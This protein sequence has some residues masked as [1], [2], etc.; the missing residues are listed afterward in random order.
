MNSPIKLGEPDRIF[1]G[2]DNFSKNV[3]SKIFFKKNGKFVWSHTLSDESAYNK[4]G[5]GDN[6][7]VYQISMNFNDKKSVDIQNEFL[8]FS[9]LKV[10]EPEPIKPVQKNSKTENTENIGFF[11]SIK[12]M[13]FN[14]QK[15]MLYIFIA[16]V[17]ITL[18]II[19][20]I[21]FMN[22][23]QQQDII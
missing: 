22:K 4:T 15:Y 5:L 1:I 8:N 21:F 17:I 23:G 12:N 16:S 14:Y 3:D 10:Q 11:D 19:G 20:I 6:Q 18:L 9:G 7:N 2:S 13:F